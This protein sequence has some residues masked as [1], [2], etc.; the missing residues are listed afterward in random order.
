M[1]GRAGI[2]AGN[3]RGSGLGSVVVVDARS[4]VVICTL[5]PSDEIGASRFGTSLSISGSVVLIGAPIDNNGRGA[6]YAFAR[7][8]VPSE[9][10]GACFSPD[11]RTLFLNVYSPTK[12]LAITGPWKW[13]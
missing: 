11:G 3:A 8:R 13:L 4:G 9:T 1:T 2:A 7:V 6:A 5:A 10:A 12:T